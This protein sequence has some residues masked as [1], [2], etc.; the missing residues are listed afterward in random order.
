MM[1]AENVTVIRQKVGN[2]GSQSENLILMYA[3]WRICSML[4][5]WILCAV[6][7]LGPWQT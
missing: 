3:I 2:V 1:I 6:F 4:G 7:G 5:I